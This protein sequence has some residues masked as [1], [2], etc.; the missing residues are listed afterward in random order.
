MEKLKTHCSTTGSGSTI[1]DDNKVYIVPDFEE[2]KRK[3]KWYRKMK[4]KVI[5]HNSSY[6][7]LRSTRKQHRR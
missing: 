1:V 4:A 2:E 7:K 3:R 6:K 5:K